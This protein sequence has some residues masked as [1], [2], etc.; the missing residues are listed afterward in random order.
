MK[1][2]RKRK[3]GVTLGIIGLIIS[4]LA[5]Y[6]NLP[7]SRLKSEFKDYLQKSEEN[8]NANKKPAIYTVNDLPEC[9]QRF[10]TY[11]GL[12][13]KTNS[14]HVQM[15]F[16][17]VDFVS[18]QRKLKIDYSEHIFGDVPSRY[19]FIDSSLFGIPFQGLDSFI[20]GK[21]G[22]KG[23][24]AKNIT[25][26][27]QRGAE[28]DQAVLVTWLSEIMFM[29]S[30]LLNGLVT[31]KEIDENS[32]VIS[33][34]YNDITVSGLFTFLEHGELIQFSTDDRAMYNNNGT[35]KK[36]KWTVLFEDYQKKEDLI[37]PNRLKAKW[38]LEE[39]ELV[40]FDGEDVEY[41]FY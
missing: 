14:T 22:M 26:F 11:T 23:V 40:Y 35:I 28:M 2:S 36:R 32:V 27:N 17:D 16:K 24:I 18:D 10:Y 39:E 19:A 8:T 9:I 5:I 25:I 15:E 29:P 1:R 37:L 13:N 41:K 6:F 21:G 31:M 30:Q 34:T 7:N 38:H 20:D 12:F 3:M 4:I 33:I